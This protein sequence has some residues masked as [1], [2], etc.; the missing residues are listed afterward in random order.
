VD[1][2]P[3]T[4][5]KKKPP[6]EIDQERLSDYDAIHHSDIVKR[7]LRRKRPFQQSGNPPLAFPLGRFRSV[8]LVTICSDLPLRRV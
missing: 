3:K 4:K 5:R 8:L 2:K 6:I 7:D 1:K